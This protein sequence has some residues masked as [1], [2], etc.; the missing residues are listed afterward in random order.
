MDIVFP[1][2][3][4]LDVHKQSV[5]V[6]AH[7]RDADG[8]KHKETRRFGTFTRD[9]LQLSDWLA[10]HKVTDV[11]MESTGVY[12]KPVYN[13]LEDAFRVLLVNAQH[14]KQVPGRK[15]DVKDCEW[16]ADLLEHG[17]LRGSFIPSRDLRELRDLTRERVQ[18]KGEHTRVANRSPPQRNVDKQSFT[19]PI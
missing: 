3:A 9:L 17:L 12:W 14:V 5:M 4:G 1:Y 13:I 16:L 10:A 19:G 11:A 18:L 15:T 8:A 2:C 6:C 7:W